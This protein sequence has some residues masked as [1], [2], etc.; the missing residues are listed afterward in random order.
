M[1]RRTVRGRPARRHDRAASRL[2]S[3]VVIGALVLATV[4]AGHELTYL[5]VYGAGYDAAMQASGHAAYWTSFIVTLGIAMGSLVVIG[6]RQLVRLRAQASR[7]DCGAEARFAALLAM[8]L[9]SVGAIGPAA[10]AVYVAQENVETAAVSG[11]FPGVGVIAGDHIVASP[12]FALI[13]AFAA[14]VYALFRWRRDVLERRILAARRRIV[15]TPPLMPGRADS[16]VAPVS[17]LAATFHGR[18]APPLT[19]ATN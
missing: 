16:A 13:A 7:A 14:S 12:V 5:L 3:L 10:L 19:P 1:R 6:A 15:P 17:R 2:R 8:W 18:R 11:A 9:R 4:A